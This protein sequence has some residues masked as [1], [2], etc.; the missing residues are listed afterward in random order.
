MSSKTLN[1]RH[2]GS[3]HGRSIL[4]PRSEVGAGNATPSTIS[5]EGTPENGED[6]K[7]RARSFSPS[8][9]PLPSAPGPLS[10]MESTPEQEESTPDHSK[11]IFNMASQQDGQSIHITFNYPSGHRGPFEV[12]M[13]FASLLGLAI[14]GASSSMR[15]VRPPYQQ[16]ASATDAST[17]QL[18]NGGQ[19][20]I[21]AQGKGFHS[22]A[23]ELRNR[24]YRLLFVKKQPVQLHAGRNF[25]R[26]SQFL[27]FQRQVHQEGASVLYGENMFVFDRSPH[28]IGRW[29]DD[30]IPETGYGHVEEC[31]RVIGHHN[32]SL[33]K[34]V[35]FIFTDAA[36]FTT[37]ELDPEDRRFVNDAQLQRCL[38]RLGKY[39]KLD[40]ITLNFDG[41]RMVT[42][43]D[44]D[45]LGA[46][47]TIMANEVHL[48]GSFDTKIKAE[49]LDFMVFPGSAGPLMSAWNKP[50]ESRFG[51]RSR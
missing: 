47:T 17:Q 6:G 21:Q 25:S 23:P 12:K 39:G 7:G 15:S 26:S 40:T 51:G 37:P 36:K 22:L 24:V 46:L 35:T 32:I 20:I 31:L 4:T 11:P 18:T 2:S 42:R 43:T 27:C 38:K 33:L 3:D 48:K 50:W 45:F 49:I 8:P 19:V 10:S 28:R 14:P 44:R 13:D 41:K 30:Y 5:L 29:F 1:T 9:P 34:D 16:Y